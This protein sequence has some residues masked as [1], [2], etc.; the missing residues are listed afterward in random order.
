MRGCAD[1][2]GSAWLWAACRTH[3]TCGPRLRGLAFSSPTVLGVVF[4]F[5]STL[6][7]LLLQLKAR[8][9]IEMR[10]SRPGA[11]LSHLSKASLVCDNDCSS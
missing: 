11:Q 9:G 5:K 3:T 8:G 10:C 7:V 4:L 1:R 2:R 6:S